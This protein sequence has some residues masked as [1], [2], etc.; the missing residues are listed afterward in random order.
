MGNGNVKGLSVNAITII[1]LLLFLNVGF[2]IKMYGKYNTMKDAGY[3]R[4]KTFEDNME[5]RVMKAFGSLEEMYKI[6]EDTTRQKEEAER[7]AAFL[8]EQELKMRR[9]NREL[10]EAKEQLLSEKEMLHKQLRDLKKLLKT[11]TGNR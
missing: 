2:A 9:L 4:E 5:K 11:K 10:T 3:V 6:V 8:K 1:L 7:T